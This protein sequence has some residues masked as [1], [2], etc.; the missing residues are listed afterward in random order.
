VKTVTSRSSRWDHGF[1]VI[2][3][4]SEEQRG[5]HNGT[6]RVN[7]FNPVVRKAKQHKW[8]RP[9]DIYDTA[10]E[11][12]FMPNLFLRRCIHFDVSVMKT[13]TYRTNTSRTER[14]GLDY[15]N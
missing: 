4:V 12:I 3:Y 13:V 14:C 8:A 7:S 5:V 1:D 11:D 10:L 6:V 15:Q 9:K 2:Y